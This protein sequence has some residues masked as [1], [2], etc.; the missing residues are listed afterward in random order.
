MTC[1]PRP[2]SPPS[3]PP[4]GTAISR[5]NDIQP[6]PPRPPR[7]S[8]SAWSTK[9]IA[10]RPSWWPRRSAA[11]GG[12]D[13]DLAAL[14]DHSAIDQRKERVVAT[15]TDVGAGLERSA[16]LPHQD[17]ADRDGLARIALHATKLGTAVAAVA[18]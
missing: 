18:G 5:R 11:L 14:K 10:Q 1:P 15:A 16:A 2:P 13:A 3:G 9:I 8:I 12:L 17:G 4:L 6:S 7:T